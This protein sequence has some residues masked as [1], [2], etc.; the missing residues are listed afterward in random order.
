MKESTAGSQTG[1][2]GRGSFV[3]G[4]GGGG[5]GGGFFFACEGFGGRSFIPH[6]RFFFFLKRRSARQRSFHFLDQDQSTAAQRAE[7]TV[8]ECSLTSCV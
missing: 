2:W 1:V 3:D 6:P 5:G 7:T 4:G 8:A